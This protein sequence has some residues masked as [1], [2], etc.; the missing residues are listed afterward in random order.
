LTAAVSPSKK[1]IDAAYDVKVLSQYLDIINV[2]T[3]D[4]HGHWD[5]KTGHVAPLRDYQGS[6]VDHFNAEF[7][8]KYWA[9][10]GAD[11]RKLVLGV[12][13]YGQAFTL[14]APADNGLNAKAPQRG[15]QGEF[16]RAAG[17]LAYYEV[18]I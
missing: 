17:F 14:A 15:L 18:P 5:K 3:Y 7:T 11:K 6:A 10:K 8:M 1:V 12:P 2:M 13:M 4:Y 16:T 9:D